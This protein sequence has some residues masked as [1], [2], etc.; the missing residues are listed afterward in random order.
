ML[1]EGARANVNC[2]FRSSAHFVRAFTK[3]SSTTTAE[4]LFDAA[5]VPYYLS[6]SSSS[7]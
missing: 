3:A 2:F 6:V 5:C 7:T 4:T 1:V